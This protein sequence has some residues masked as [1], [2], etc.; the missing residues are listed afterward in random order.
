MSEPD[1]TGA[2][3]P[4]HAP[5]PAERFPPGTLLASRYRVVAPLGR[6]GMGEVYRADDL[7]L[8]QPVALKF[9]PLHIAQDP[10]PPTRFRKEVASARRVSHP[11]VCRLYDIADHDGQSFLTMEFIDG[12]D[13]SS[14]LK[15]LGREPAVTDESAFAVRFRHLA[16]HHGPA[17]VQS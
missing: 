13:L 17:P 16:R 15:R 12:E 9:L 2:Y 5:M 7:T 6:G 1:A 14:V 3:Q 10:D 11:N 8:G 4:A